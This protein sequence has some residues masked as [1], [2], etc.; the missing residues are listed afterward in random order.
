[1]IAFTRYVASAG[2]AS[3]VDFVLVQ[4]L[5][6]LP[7][8]QT[9]PLFGLAIALGAIAGMSV[10]FIL[11]RRFVFGREGQ[12]S[13]A[14]RIRFV[15][16]SLT[17]LVLRIA[18]A[19]AAMSVLVLPVFGWVAG[20]PLDAPVTRLSHITAMGLVTIY[21]FFAHKHISFALPAGNAGAQLAGR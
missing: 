18:V 17:T 21:S 12:A 16:I 11:S 15:L 6:V 7:M 3:L 1:M 4:T 13:A 20:L 10:N 19:Y 2:A 5:L 8:L 14:E 9:G